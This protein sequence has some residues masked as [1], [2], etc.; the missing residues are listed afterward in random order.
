MSFTLCTSGA[1]T[2]KA[3]TNANTTILG[4]ETALNKLAD[5]AEGRIM[6]ETHSDWVTNYNSLSDGIKNVL[7]DVAS[8]LIAMMIVGYD[9]S[10]YTTQREAETILDINDDRASKGLSFLKDKAKQKLGT[11]P[12]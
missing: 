3:G 2:I 6:A 1:A 9:I 8:S 11:P 5:E 10:S 7:S 12:T 4:D